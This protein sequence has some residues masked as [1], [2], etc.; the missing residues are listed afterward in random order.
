MKA[1]N[2]AGKQFG[3]LTALTRKSEVVHNKRRSLWLC[4]C[5]CGAEKEVL[6]D[7]LVGGVVRSCGCLRLETTASMN[8]RH[9]MSKGRKESKEYKAWSHAK[10]RCYN[11]N[12]KKYINYGARGIKM[13]ERWLQSPEL[14]LQ[15]M[16][17]C[18]EGLTLD[19]ID[20]EGDY[21]PSNCRWASIGAQS[22]NK[23][24]MVHIQYNGET[25]IMIE[26]AE[27]FGIPYKQFHHLYRYKKLSMEEIERTTWR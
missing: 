26:W 20:V 23:T 27:T 7:C 14:F 9:G 2:L 5:E 12:D 15:D 22:R 24:T 13:C 18:P 10:S 8:Y 19:R 17:E 6:S 16:G 1:L 4:K 3:R 25:K 21:E 11:P